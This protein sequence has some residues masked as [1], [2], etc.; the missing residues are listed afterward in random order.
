MTYFSY[1]PFWDGKQSEY[2]GPPNLYVS[3]F[4]V[5]LKSSLELSSV[6]QW[7][8]VFKPFLLG[9]LMTVL[10]GWWTF[11]VELVIWYQTYIHYTDREKPKPNSY[12]LIAKC[13]TARIL[14]YVIWIWKQQMLTDIF[15]VNFAFN[16]LF[17]SLFFNYWIYELELVTN[18]HGKGRKFS[19][20]I[21]YFQLR[22][23]FFIGHGFL[24]TVCDWLQMYQ[25]LLYVYAINMICYKTWDHSYEDITPEHVTY[26]PGCIDE[27][28]EMD[29]GVYLETIQPHI[30]KYIEKSKLKSRW[31]SLIDNVTQLSE[32]IEAVSQWISSVSGPGVSRIYISDPVNDHEKTS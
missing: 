4:V 25:I 11:W 32:K 14:T 7:Q 1:I 19:Q 22:T 21:D 13:L 23:A 6:T 29:Y 18:G 10:F 8:R 5:G 26:I 2:G 12:T 3:N 27:D 9:L 24:I 20:R 30:K 16:M 31:E 15:L 28:P 17:G